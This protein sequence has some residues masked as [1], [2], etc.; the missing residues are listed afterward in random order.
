MLGQVAGRSSTEDAACI[1][2]RAIN[3]R[4]N[5]RSVNGNGARTVGRR[6]NRYDSSYETASM[7]DLTVEDSAWFPLRLSPTPLHGAASLQRLLPISLTPSE[8]RQMP[9][10]SRDSQ[11]VPAGSVS[12]EQNCA[13]NL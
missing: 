10:H 6:P 9:P 13:I 5:S 1:R 7:V 8:Q 12:R 2:L 11:E 4:A 3:R